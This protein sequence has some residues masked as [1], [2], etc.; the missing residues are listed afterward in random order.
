MKSWHKSTTYVVCDRRT[1]EALF[2]TANSEVLTKL[3]TETCEAIGI[4]EYMERLQTQINNS[5]EGK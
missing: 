5:N 4:L 2:E 3:N 1:G